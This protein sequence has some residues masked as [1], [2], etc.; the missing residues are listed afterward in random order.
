MP[1]ALAFLAL[2]ALTAQAAPPY[3]TDVSK[4]AEVPIPSH[5]NEVEYQLWYYASNYSRLEWR[6]FE[7]DGAPHAKL[8]VDATP[9]PKERPGFIPV[10]GEFRGE[11]AYCA[12][13]RVD[14]GWLVGFNKGEFGAALYW[15]S[16]DGK[17]NY[18]ISDHQVWQFFHLPDG[19]YAVEGLAHLT[20]NE[21]S[22]IR[23]TRAD[24]RSHWQARTVVRLPAAPQAG[25]VMSDGTLILALHDALVRI[26]RNHTVHTLLAHSP[27]ESLYPNSSILVDHEQKLYLGMRQ[28]VAEFD[29]RTRKLRFLVPS[30]RFMNKLPRKREQEIRN[31]H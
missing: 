20:M 19:V 17:R 4:W 11:S 26:D 5:K 8:V 14:D 21:G 13:A 28:Y 31:G 24:S 29:L 18:K 10:A 12:F 7:R 22:L 27:W 9:E 2:L 23:I 6:V 16:A 3:S 1:R 30:P 25:S 15:F